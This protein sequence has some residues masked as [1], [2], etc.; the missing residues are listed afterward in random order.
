MKKTF[1]SLCTFMFALLILISPTLGQ[2]DITTDNKIG[3]VGGVVVI[4]FVIIL[5]YL[6]RLEKKLSNLEKY[7]EGEE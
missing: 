2:S 5:L 7:Q 3:V 6:L 1:Y 4:I